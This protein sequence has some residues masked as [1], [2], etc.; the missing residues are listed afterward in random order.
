[1]STAGPNA[2]GSSRRQEAAAAP[3]GR[4]AACGKSRVNGRARAIKADEQ[5]AQPRSPVVDEAGPLPVEGRVQPGERFTHAVGAVEHADVLDA[6]RK[7]RAPRRARTE[8]AIGHAFSRQIAARLV[9]D[10]KGFVLKH[11][12][13]EGA[14]DHEQIA[15]RE[16]CG[17]RRKHRDRDGRFDLRMRLGVTDDDVGGHRM[18]KQSK[19]SVAERQAPR[20][21]RRLRRAARAALARSPA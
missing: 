6:A 18:A 16:R 8:I 1:M 19:P 13:L 17:A 20:D 12:G 7:R 21:R 3:T 2:S 15:R 10:A 5:K 4:A 14:N 9:G 11:G